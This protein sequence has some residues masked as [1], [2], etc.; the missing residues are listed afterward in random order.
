MGYTTYS[1]QQVLELD[2]LGSYLWFWLVC[3]LLRFLFH[4]YKMGYMWD[5]MGE[6]HALH[7]V[8][9]IKVLYTNLVAPRLAHCQPRSMDACP[10]VSPNFQPRSTIS[11]QDL[12]E[13]HQWKLLRD[14]LIFWFSLIL[15]SSIK[16]QNKI[17]SGPLSWKTLKQTHEIQARPVESKRNGERGK[18]T[19]DDWNKSEE[20]GTATCPRNQSTI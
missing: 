6:W 12:G 18:V 14:T 20:R 4:T 17:I 16:K 9:L 8:N 1:L 15:F 19:R 13:H 5:T 3:Y 7:W 2:F 11:L 10:L